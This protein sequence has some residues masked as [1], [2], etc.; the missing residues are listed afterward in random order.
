MKPLS[1]SETE[2]WRARMNAALDPSERMARARMLMQDAWDHMSEKAREDFYRRNISKRA[3][4]RR[5]D[6]A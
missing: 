4:S 1:Q 3:I 5:I 2:L 6:D